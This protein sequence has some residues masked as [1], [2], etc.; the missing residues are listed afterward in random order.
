LQD[1]LA[2]SLLLIFIGTNPGLLTAYTGH[3]YSSPT[4]SF[5]KLL[6]ASKL[7]LTESGLPLQAT[8][9]RT[10]PNRFLLGNTNIVERASRSQEDLSREEM[11]LGAGRTVKK[12]GRWRPEAVCVVGKGVWEAFVGWGRKLKLEKGESGF[13]GAPV[14]GKVFKWGWQVDREGRELRMGVGGGGSDESEGKDEGELEIPERSWLVK[15]EYL[16]PTPP[17]YEGSWEGARVYV[18][19]ST[20]GLVT[21][22]FTKKLEIW[23]GVGEWVGKRREDRGFTFS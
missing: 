14:A 19:P 20:S 18:V 6:H 2:P 10:L 3:T 11:V 1:I 22:P 8:E 21:M 15:S 9:D 4:N 7:T 17:K 23:K 13:S 12:I 5:W 16:V